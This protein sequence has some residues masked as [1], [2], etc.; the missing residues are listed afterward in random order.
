MSKPVSGLNVFQNQAG[1]IP[2]SQ[3][4]A[5]FN[6]HAAALNDIGTYSNYFADASGA[7]NQLT[8]TIAPPLTFA[9]VTGIALQ[10]RIANTNTSTTVNINVNSLGNRTIVLNDGVAPPVGALTTG[11]ILDLMYDGT[12]FRVLGQRA[13][14]ASGLFGDGS[15]GSPSISFAADTDTGDYR[16][17]P[18]SEVRVVGGVSAMQWILSGGTAQVGVGNGTVTAPSMSFFNDFDNGA[19]LIGTND[20]GFSTGGTLAMEIFGAATT[21]VGFASGTATNPG[22]TFIGDTNTGDFRNGPDSLVRVVGGTSAMQW[23]LSGAVVQVGGP[24]GTAAQPGISWFGDFDTGLFNTT[25]NRISFACGGADTASVDSSRFG[26]AVPFQSADGAVG[27]PAFSWLNDTNTGLYRSAA[28]TFNFSVGGTSL[29]QLSASNPA[30]TIG[31]GSG[32]QWVVGSQVST[33]VGLAG[34][35]AALPATPLGYL[36]WQVNGSNVKIP[37]YNT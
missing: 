32:T 20:Y 10:I 29:M 14:I 8:V 1:P 22:I 27:A 21:Q 18:N 3:L 7:P 37:Y 19:Y 35:A 5:N 13:V 11:T 16:N 15:S 31:I 23:I 6:L 12:S 28:D 36:V 2:L 30:I 33:T 26:S 25:P 34:G 17:G 9:Y 24:A 4:D